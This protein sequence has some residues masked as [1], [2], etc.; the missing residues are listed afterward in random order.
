MVLIIA[1]KECE[2]GIDPIEGQQFNYNE[3]Y[4]IQMLALK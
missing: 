3:L 4:G 1:G 2:F